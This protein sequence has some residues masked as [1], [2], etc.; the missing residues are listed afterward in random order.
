MLRRLRPEYPGTVYLMM[1]SECIGEGAGA[2][3]GITFSLDDCDGE[4]F[5][6]VF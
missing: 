1:N 4:L 6:P 3:K 2:F 5:L